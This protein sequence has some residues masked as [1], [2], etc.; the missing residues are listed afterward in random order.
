MGKYL[1]HFNTESEYEE[2]K[3]NS[4]QFVQP[5]VSAIGIV[6]DGSGNGDM[7]INNVHFSAQFGSGYGE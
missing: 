4:G 2:F 1:K 5:N 6:Q 7:T 3:N